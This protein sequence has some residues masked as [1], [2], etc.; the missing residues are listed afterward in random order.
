MGNGPTRLTAA[1]GSTPE[2][3]VHCIAVAGVSLQC[4]IDSQL[5][6]VGITPWFALVVL[7]CILKLLLQAKLAGADSG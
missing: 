5:V 7:Y 2:L 3:V 1:T 6:Q 4:A